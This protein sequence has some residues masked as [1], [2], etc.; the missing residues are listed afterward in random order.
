MTKTLSTSAK[1]NA[2]EAAVVPAVEE[3]DWTYADFHFRS[4]DKL[5]LVEAVRIDGETWYLI[6][7]A[8]R[9]IADLVSDTYTYHVEEDIDTTRLITHERTGETRRFINEAQFAHL[10]LTWSRSFVA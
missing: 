2:I 6:A 10:L 1:K 3:L 9:L 4:D 5:R 7:D 8:V